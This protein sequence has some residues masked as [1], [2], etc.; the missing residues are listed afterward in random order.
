MK[1]LISALLIV[2]MLLSTFSFMA[3]AKT[4]C[5]HNYKTYVTAATTSKNGSA[6]KKCTKCGSKTSSTTIK[7]ISSVKLSAESYTYSGEEKKPS[8]TVKDSAGKKLKSGTDYSVKYPSAM[9][10]VGTY[11]VKVTFKG[12]YS[13]S[14]TLKFKILPKGT[15][16]SSVEKSK[17]TITV[18]WKKQSTQVTGYQLQYSTGSDFSSAK[19]ATITSASTTSRTIKDLSYNKKYYVR[20]RTYK[21]V[22]DTKYYS[23]WSEKK[24]VTTSPKCSIAL[25]DSEITLEVGDVATLFYSISPKDTKVTWKSS[26]SAVAKVSSSGVVTAVSSGTANITASFVYD[27]T[28]YKDSCS[29]DV[30]SQDDDSDTDYYDEIIDH[31]LTYGDFYFEKTDSKGTRYGGI[32]SISDDG[33]LTFFITYGLTAVYVEYEKGSSTAYLM[34][35]T[36]SDESH[37][38]A[39]VYGNADVNVATYEPGDSLYF[40]NVKYMTGYASVIDA[41]K[42]LITSVTSIGFLCWDRELSSKLGISM[43]DIGFLGV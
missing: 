9:T 40:Y 26:N 11:S 14:K 6:Y 7:K 20:I 34:G 13:G 19:T 27:G 17:N 39:V 32:I 16:L 2:V 10:K 8:V 36:Y 37:N 29:V 42:N 1:K 18:K 33:N 3:S 15:T 41:A 22:D 4:A 30:Y 38:T 43:S 24:N 28:T 35:A 21:T 12:N 25:D 5:S 31:I 23:S